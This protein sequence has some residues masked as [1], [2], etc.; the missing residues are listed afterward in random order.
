MNFQHRLFVLVLIICLIIVPC[1][2]IEIPPEERI[3][4]GDTIPYGQNITSIDSNVIPCRD[5]YLY[6][7]SP[8][9][10]TIS[11]AGASFNTYS[12]EYEWATNTYE[13]K[14]VSACLGGYI[15]GNIATSPGRYYSC[16]NP[17]SAT[18]IRSELVNYCSLLFT[19]TSGTP[20]FSNYP[21]RFNPG[22]CSCLLRQ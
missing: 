8:D 6:R 2:A 3:H 4:R 7:L 14:P 11:Y 18:G 13:Q 9:N 20:E 22:K 5:G 12:F 19:C 10:T 15:D 21:D 16:A 1:L 17:L